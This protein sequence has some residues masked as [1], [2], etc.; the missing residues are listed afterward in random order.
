VKQRELEG[1][2]I[3]LN[4]EPPRIIFRKK[5]KGGINISSTV[6]LT[7]LDPDTIKVPTC[8]WHDM[9]F[10]LFPTPVRTHRA[11]AANTASTTRT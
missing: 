10:V 11:S 8:G 1:F 6:A 2:G 7:N 3:R 5:E 4:K 9:C